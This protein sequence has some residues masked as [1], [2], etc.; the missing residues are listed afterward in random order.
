MTRV[1]LRHAV[2]FAGV[3]IFWNGEVN[4]QLTLAMLALILY[5]FLSSQFAPYMDPTDDFLVRRVL[6][7]QLSSVRPS[8]HPSVR[9]S[10]HSPARSS[11]L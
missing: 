8:V 4:V 1:S 2:F 7:C 11:D 6:A 5:F 10:T 3:L 9:P